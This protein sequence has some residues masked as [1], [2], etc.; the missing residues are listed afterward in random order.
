MRSMGTV[1]ALN[2]TYRMPPLPVALAATSPLSS[3]PYRRPSWSWV[4]SC[5][6]LLDHGFFENDF[7]FDLLLALL[8]ARRRNGRIRHHG[9]GIA[10]VGNFRGPLIGLVGSVVVVVGLIVGGDVS[11]IDHLLAAALPTSAFLVAPASR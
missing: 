7:I 6:F 10:V 11:E 5:P 2:S 9:V 4:S 3:H 1:N 8:F